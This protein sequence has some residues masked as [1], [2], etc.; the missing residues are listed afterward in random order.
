MKKIGITIFIFLLSI[1]LIGCQDYYDV[2][3]DISEFAHWDGNYIYFGN[4]RCKTTGDDEEQLIETIIYND[5]EYKVQEC[6]HYEFVDDKI[7]MIMYFERTDELEETIQVL[8]EYNIYNKSYKVLCDLDNDTYYWIEHIYKGEYVFI[9]SSYNTVRCSLTTDEVIFINGYRALSYY[10]DLIIAN[11][12]GTLLYNKYNEEVTKTITAYEENL[13]YKLVTKNDQKYLLI[14]IYDYAQPNVYYGS[15]TIYDFKTDKI[16]EIISHNDQKQFKILNDDYIIFY[17][18]KEFEYVSS[19]QKVGNLLYERLTENLNVN[20]TLYEVVYDSYDIENVYDFENKNIDYT[21]GTIKDNKYIV[22][23]KKVKRG[24]QLIPGYTK[25]KWVQLDLETFKLSKVKKTKTEE[26][27]KNTYD[28]IKCGDYE[29]Y[30]V[31][32][33]IGPLMGS[34]YAYFLYQKDANGNTSIMQFFTS[35]Y[36][37]LRG[38]RYSEKFALWY[39]KYRSMDELLILNY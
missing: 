34:H 20:N 32:E 27:T 35:T 1:F 14:A 10:D 21:N 31:N 24:N 3:P 15:L 26:I 6:E 17:E 5:V 9:A 23:S 7:Y 16:N 19:I 2:E 36:P 12:Y 37:S 8:L 13:T 38:V 33:K 30:F 4:T 25:E 39:S 28:S 22:S 29:Y 11:Q 18:N